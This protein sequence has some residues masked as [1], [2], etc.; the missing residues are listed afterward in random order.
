MNIEEHYALLGHSGYSLCLRKKTLFAL[1][2]VKTGKWRWDWRISQ[3]A[4]KIRI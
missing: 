3:I 2:Y 1:L 4:I